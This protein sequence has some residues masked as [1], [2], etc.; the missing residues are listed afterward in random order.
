MM[1]LSNV[2]R[3]DYPLA[4][5]RVGWRAR[6]RKARDTWLP[7]T[8]AVEAA[9]EDGFLEGVKFTAELLEKEG[10]RD[11]ANRVRVQIQRKV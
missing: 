10:D 11:L 4:R 8:Y 9:I 6:A 3:A 7:G 1:R 5:F 2:E